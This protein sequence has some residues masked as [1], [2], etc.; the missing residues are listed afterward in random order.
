MI[1]LVCVL[2]VLI[3]AGCSRAVVEDDAGHEAG[4]P[5]ALKWAQRT[6]PFQDMKAI[7]PSL[8]YDYDG[9]RIYTCCES[10]LPL[11]RQDPELAIQ[12]L[13]S[14]GEYVMT[15][16]AAKEREARLTPYD[17]STLPE[18]DQNL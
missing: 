18:Q 12:N 17:F 14:R 3:L 6:C 7:E 2:A 16:E 8:Y 1:R 15:I 4:S 5:V 11:V 13:A 10:C 9:H